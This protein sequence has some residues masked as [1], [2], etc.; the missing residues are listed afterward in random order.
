MESHERSAQM[1]SLV[2]QLQLS[3]RSQ[4]EFSK[5]QGIRPATLSY[6]VRKYKQHQHSEKGFARVELAGRQPSGTVA[7]IEVELA[8][9][10]VIRIF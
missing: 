7:R 3:G 1:F 10:I 2:E 6:W 4:K 9:G 8:D 5:E